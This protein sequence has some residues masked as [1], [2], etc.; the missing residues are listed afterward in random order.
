LAGSF[1]TIVLED[2]DVA[3]MVKKSKEENRKD[4]KAFDSGRG[5]L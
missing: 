3:G 5:L 2:L 1:E 4:V